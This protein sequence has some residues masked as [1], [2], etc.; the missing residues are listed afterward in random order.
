MASVWDHIFGAVPDLHDQNIVLGYGNLLGRE[1][2]QYISV[3]EQ[4]RRVI[5]SGRKHD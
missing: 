1:A 4:V 5:K 3:R 2:Q